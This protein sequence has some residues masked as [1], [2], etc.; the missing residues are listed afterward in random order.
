M[1]SRIVTKDDKKEWNKLK[2]L[3]QKTKKR[4]AGSVDIGLFGNQGSDLVYYATVNEFGEG[5][6]PERSFLRSAIDENKEKIRKFVTIEFAKVV[7]REQTM[8]KFTKRLGVF[9]VALVQAKIKKGPFKKNHPITIKRK[10][11]DKPLI[12]TGRMRQS[13]TFRVR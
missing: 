6:V 1:S 5:R 13:I 8:I 10:G 12:D 9:G 7:K 11:S 3:I 4:G 2:R